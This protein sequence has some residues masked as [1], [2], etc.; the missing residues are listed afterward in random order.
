MGASPVVDGRLLLPLLPLTPPL[1]CGTG[2]EGADVARAPVLGAAAE[3]DAGA[4]GAGRN[5]KR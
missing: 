3:V 1:A 4:D 5:A 2:A